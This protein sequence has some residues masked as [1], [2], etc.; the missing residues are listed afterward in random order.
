MMKKSKYSEQQITALLREV[1]LGAKVNETCRKYG[2]SDA[3]YYKWK[4]AYGWYYGCIAT[5]ASE[6]TSSRERQAQEDVC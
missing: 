2:I 6:G 4:S 5:Q 1:E 3:T